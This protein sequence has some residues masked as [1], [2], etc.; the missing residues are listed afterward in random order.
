ML[1]AIT[2]STKRLTVNNK[3]YLV[4]ITLVDLFLLWSIL[5]VNIAINLILLALNI[6]PPRSGTF[7]GAYT[8]RRRFKTG[9]GYTKLAQL[10]RK[11]RQ[12]TILF[13]NIYIISSLQ[14]IPI[15][16]LKLLHRCGIEIILN[17]NGLYYPAWYSGSYHKKNKYYYEVAQLAKHVFYQ[18]EFCQA[19]SDQLLG[20]LIT[21]SS[22]ILLNP[23]S[24]KIEDTVLASSFSA[25]HINI[26]VA[27]NF[28]SSSEEY[29]INLAIEALNLL[30]PSLGPILLTIAGHI[31]PDL[32]IRN[33]IAHQASSRLSINILGPYAPRVLPSLFTKSDR[34]LHLTSMDSCPNL[35]IESLSMGCPVIGLG[36]GG[37][38]ELINSTNGVLIAA[39][40]NWM[41][42]T[43][44]KQH[45]ITSAIETSLSTG[46]DR[47][48]ISKDALSRHNLINW[49]SS[50]D[51]FL[52][53]D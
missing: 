20:P 33:I 27:G 37:T 24:I 30:N 49:L 16:P 38:A 50:H 29:R 21:K 39:Q 18:S 48:L 46:Y 44:P 36:N 19:S 35:V 25:E 32:K 45:D 52:G 6:T 28:Y 14:P 12:K 40:N 26:L 4:S 10:S 5:A 15:L 2:S 13:R 22:S 42:R 43:L 11:F 7:Y 23:S 53:N 1:N 47:Q 17:Q 9:G 3:A 51:Q 8:F 31:S 34:Y 41:T